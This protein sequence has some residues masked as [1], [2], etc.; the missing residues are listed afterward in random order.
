MPRL[1]AVPSPRAWPSLAAAA[2]VLLILG[3][4]VAVGIGDAL[5][6]TFTPAATPA[7]SRRLGAVGPMPRRRPR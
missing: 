7:A 2:V 6:L 5:G 3:A 1:A 4:V